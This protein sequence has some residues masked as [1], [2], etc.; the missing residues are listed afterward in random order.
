MPRSGIRVV[1]DLAWQLESEGQKVIHLQV[2]QPD[3]ES[4]SHAVAAS[5]ES[6]R[7][8]ETSILRTAGSTSFAMPS[9]GATRLRIQ[10]L[11]RR[12]TTFCAP[13]VQCLA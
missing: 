6:L 7:R 4:P 12:E 10:M 3:F 5:I 11:L 9:P 2:G 13:M 8:G 1:M